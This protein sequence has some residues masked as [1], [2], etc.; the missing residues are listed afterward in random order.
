VENATRLLALHLEATT[1]ILLNATVDGK[2]LLDDTQDGGS[3]IG[4]HG[5]T[6]PIETPALQERAGLRVS[7][8]TS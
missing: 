1:H 2:R 5:R 4:G 3:I 7:T 6:S 8:T